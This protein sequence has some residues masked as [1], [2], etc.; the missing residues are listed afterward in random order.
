MSLLM[1]NI[2]PPIHYYAPKRSANRHLASQITEFA[3]LQYVGHGLSKTCQKHTHI[4]TGVS[5]LGL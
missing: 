1:I 3:K 5:G 4:Y 2:G